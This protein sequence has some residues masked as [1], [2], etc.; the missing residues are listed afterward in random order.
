MTETGTPRA[1]LSGYHET[2]R[3]GFYGGL[4]AIE[5]IPRL[6]KLLVPNPAHLSPS[7]MSQVHGGEPEP[8]RQ[9]ELFS[10]YESD[11]E[12]EPEP[13]SEPEPISVFVRQ[14]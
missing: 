12:S 5:Q 4:R 2:V 8:Q 3:A 6:P 13:S 1:A 14:Y 9:S 10:K 11:P 7:P